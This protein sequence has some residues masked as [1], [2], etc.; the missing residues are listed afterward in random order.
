MTC[1]GRGPDS[2]SE[3]NLCLPDPVSSTSRVDG[4]SGLRVTSHKSHRLDEEAEEAF[5]SH[6]EVRRGGR[7]GSDPVRR[8]EG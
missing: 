6:S 7:W 3:G 5:V 8:V 4:D 2:E 1:K